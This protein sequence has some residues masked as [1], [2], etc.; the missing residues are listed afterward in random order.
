MEC[1]LV[2]DKRRQCDA[3]RLPGY[4]HRFN[5]TIASA[6]SG[7]ILYSSV[8]SQRTWDAARLRCGTG[9]CA[10]R[11]GPGTRAGRKLA[12]GQLHFVQQR[13]PGQHVTGALGDSLVDF[14]RVVG[15]E[16]PESADVV[17]GPSPFRHRRRAG[18]GAGGRTAASAGCVS[19]ASSAISTT[20]PGTPH[21]QPQV[22]ESPRLLHRLRL[23]LLGRP[24]PF[25][26]LAG[27]SWLASVTQQYVGSTCL[28]N[29]CMAYLIKAAGAGIKPAPA[30]AWRGSSGL[31]A[32]V[33]GPK[34]TIPGIHHFSQDSSIFS[35][36]NFRSSSVRWAK[37]PWRCR[38][39]VTGLRRRMPRAMARTG[40]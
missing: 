23:Q 24:L 17:D 10:A 13:L 16:T 36:K 37:R 1:L 26:N 29:I 28:A 12:H 30:M 2:G 22:V 20:G 34:G 32:F 3:I 11:R 18:A 15:Q 6:T 7:C 14:P 8:W 21:R 27:I 40:R 31:R 38:Y 4:R 5:L 25:F 9:G 33:V 35:W 19:T 39:S